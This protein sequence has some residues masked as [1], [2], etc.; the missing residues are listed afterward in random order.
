MSL[1]SLAATAHTCRRRKI[2][3]I[4]AMDAAATS[5]RPLGAAASNPAACAGRGVVRK[6][7]CRP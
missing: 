6:K 7:C 1:S 2:E 4:T 3:A 5:L